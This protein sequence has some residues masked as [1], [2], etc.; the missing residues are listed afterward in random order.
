MARAYRRLV[1]TCPAGQVI[2]ICSGRLHALREVLDLA[3]SITGH[4]PRV[5]VNPAF[6]RAKEVRSLGG[7]PALL[8][9]II[10]EWESPPLEETLRWMLAAYP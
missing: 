2:N 6:V 8:R 7:D 4:R 9:S 10:G 3:A 1:E 5:D